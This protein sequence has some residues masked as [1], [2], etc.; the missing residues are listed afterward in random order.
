[1][2]GVAKAV[3]GVV[4]TKFDP[5]TREHLSELETLAKD[6]GPEAKTLA[7]ATIDLSKQAQVVIG[8][9]VLTYDLRAFLLR[10]GVQP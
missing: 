8:Q 7:R 4:I 5:L 3:I 9:S 10:A 2:P 1:M 6:G